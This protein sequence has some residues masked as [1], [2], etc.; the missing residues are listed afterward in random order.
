MPLKPDVIVIGAGISGLAAARQLCA[1]GRKVLI[2]EARDRLGGRIHTYR[3]TDGKHNVDLGA[4]FIHGIFGNPIARLAKDLKLPLY[5]GTHQGRKTLDHTGNN[6]LDPELE[7]LIRTNVMT[8]IFGVLRQEAQYGDEIPHSTIPLA[9]PLFHPESP[10]YDNLPDENIS[11]A[12]FYAEAAAR[13]LDGWTGASLDNISFQWWGWEQETQGPD[14]YVSDGYSKIID[15]LAREIK[16]NSEIRLNEE[17]ISIQLSGDPT[18]DDTRVIVKTSPTSKGQDFELST[19]EAPLVLITI[20]LG[21]LK[22]NPPNFS[23]PL[24]LRRVEAI[25]SLGF[26]ILNKVVLCYNEPWWA[27]DVDDWMFLPNPADPNHI[28]GPLGN[29]SYRLSREE[30]PG[31]RALYVLNLWKLAKTP[32]VAFFIGGYTADGLELYDNH[33]IGNWAENIFNQYVSPRSVPPK[34]VKVLCTR[35]RSD[36]FSRGS[37]AY[38]PINKVDDVSPRGPSDIAKDP[39][40]IGEGNGGSPLDLEELG[41]PL[42]GRFFFAGEHTSM[43]HFASVHGAYTSGIR[44]ADKILG[45]L[46]EFDAAEQ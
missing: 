33:Q 19:Y 26:G 18:A 34:P 20:P 36:P 38:L 42:W 28:E 35:W 17:V 14:A 15:W 7:T 25:E 23:P 9:E 10:L 21:V 45:A 13:A 44:E 1:A 22:Y 40:L 16:N 37:Y 3:S 31:S 24:P 11:P 2:L 43:N 39:S 6:P 46:E 4:S 5:V 27:K 29:A 30:H 8:T 12:R 41:H 32:A